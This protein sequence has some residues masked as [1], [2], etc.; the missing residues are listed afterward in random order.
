MPV[1]DQIDAIN[2][3]I[4]EV[5]KPN[6]ITTANAL[7]TS[8]KVMIINPA[9]A[10]GE[11]NQIEASIIVAS[12][13]KVPFSDLGNIN[14]ILLDQA[15]Q[16]KGYA[17]FDENESVIYVYKGVAN[18]L[19]TD[20]WAFAKKPRI[21]NSTIGASYTIQDSLHLSSLSYVNA[22]AKVITLDKDPGLMTAGFTSD[23]FRDSEGAVTVAYDAQVIK[24]H[25]HD[26]STGILTLKKAS[27]E[28][29]LGGCVIRYEGVDNADDKMVY[30][31][32]GAIENV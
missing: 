2:T 5:V 19:I 26:P 27:D 10:D 15:N 16:I 32:F 22:N 30:R 3:R 12:G 6:N 17:V 1:Q 21:T 9:G 23:H 13:Q 31:I 7:P 25:H 11:I 28:P 4:S 14:E 29:S 8:A 24:V 18:G 20:Y